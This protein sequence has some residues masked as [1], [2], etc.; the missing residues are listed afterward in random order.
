VQAVPASILEP[1]S[2]SEG[3]FA[4]ILT[5]IVA[6]TVVFADRPD[7]FAGTVPTS[8]VV[9]AV[10][11]LA[12]NGDPANAAL[13]GQLPD[14]S[15]EIVIVE[16]LSAELGDGGLTYDVRL[17]GADTE[18]SFGL[19]A[20]PLSDFTGRRDYGASTLFVDDIWCLLD[21]RC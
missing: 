10:N 11:E 17:L 19:E 20:E 14:G 16:L 3:G 2:G 1:D 7:R 8:D 18:L 21:G 15:E 13:V 5:D 6:Q 4:L 9:D 12:Q